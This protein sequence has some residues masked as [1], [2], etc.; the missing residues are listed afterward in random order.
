MPG[1]H[2]ERSDRATDMDFQEDLVTDDSVN[3]IINKPAI[4]RSEIV[5]PT[6]EFPD[7]IVRREMQLT[8]RSVQFNNVTDK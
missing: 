5:P 7:N 1:V 6:E 4:L 3:D 8:D 2:A